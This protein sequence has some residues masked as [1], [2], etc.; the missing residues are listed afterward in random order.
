[1]TFRELMKE[2][3]FTQSRLSREADV[4]QSNLSIYSNYRNTLESSSMLTRFKI[5]KAMGMTLEEFESVL[6][7]SPASIIASN[8]QQGDYKI[9]EVN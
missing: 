1:M 2:K 5:S 8:K 7:L 3:G 6:E 4:S 9:T